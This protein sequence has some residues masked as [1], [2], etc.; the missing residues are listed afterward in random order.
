MLVVCRDPEIG[1]K[2]R[3]ALNYIGYGT[4]ST[5]NN[6]GQG[7]ERMKTRNF[8]L[9]VFD[10]QPSNVTP[11]DFVRQCKV[12]VSDA[13]LLALSYNPSV[14]D[15]FALLR[16]GARGFVVVPFTVDALEAAI[17]RAIIGPPLSEVIL[18]AADRN[19]A[20]AGLV[21]NMLYRLTSRMRHC[22]QFP[23]ALNLVERD[24]EQLNEAMQLA[25]T[26]C[27]GGPMGLRDKILEGCQQ[28]AHQPST[29]LGRTRQRLKK[30]REQRGDQRA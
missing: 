14:E 11:L 12:L 6:H 10:A 25:L 27:E 23:F 15:V 19:A 1:L 28:R 20:L 7:I 21:L 4:V 30:L 5:V 8:E 9:I 24:K 3:Q 22:R 26:F 18:E 16:E 17:E 2:T 13:T 29:R